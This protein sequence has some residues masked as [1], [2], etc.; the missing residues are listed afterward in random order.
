MGDE[1]GFAHWII[2]SGGVLTAAEALIV[3]LSGRYG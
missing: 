3:G 1:L 2:V